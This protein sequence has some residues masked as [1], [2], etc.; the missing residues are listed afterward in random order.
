[1]SKRRTIRRTQKIGILIMSSC[2]L[3]MIIFMLKAP[4]LGIFSF[5]QAVVVPAIPHIDESNSTAD[6]AD[7][8]EYVVLELSSHNLNLLKTLQQ[9]GW[10]AYLANGTIHIGPYLKSFMSQLNLS[11]ISQITPIPVR[12]TYD[13]FI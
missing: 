13:H 7:L 2:A 3:L 9:Q 1:M 8:P 12:I 4:S 5:N 6:A 10:P 11:T